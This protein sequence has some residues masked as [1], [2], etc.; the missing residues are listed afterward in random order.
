MTLNIFTNITNQYYE[1]CVKN[2][3]LIRVSIILNLVVETPLRS[4]QMVRY[5]KK[6]S[7]YFL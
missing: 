2:L 7:T 1:I 6:K 3:V 5:I 4:V